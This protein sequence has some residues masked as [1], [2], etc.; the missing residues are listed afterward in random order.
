MHTKMSLYA[1]FFPKSV[2]IETIWCALH[3]SFFTVYCL[4]CFEHYEFDVITVQT[5]II[6]FCISNENKMECDKKILDF[7]S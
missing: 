7:F 1:H 3:T 2:C 5:P 4:R 6:N